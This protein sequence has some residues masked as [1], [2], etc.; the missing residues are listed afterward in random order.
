[1]HFVTIIPLGIAILLMIIKGFFIG[2]LLIIGLIVWGIYAL[3][4]KSDKP[5]EEEGDE[6]DQAMRKSEREIEFWDRKM[7]EQQE[8][9]AEFYR[10]IGKLEQQLEDLE[11]QVGMKKNRKRK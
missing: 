9:D 3:F 6:W 7:R 8:D 2:L 5:K 1:M 10:R 4:F 11:N